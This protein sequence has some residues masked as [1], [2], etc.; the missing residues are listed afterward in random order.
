LIFKEK[1]SIRKKKRVGGEG[2]EKKEVILII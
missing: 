2:K 1:E